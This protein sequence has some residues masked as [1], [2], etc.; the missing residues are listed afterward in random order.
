MAR[1]PSE[2]NLLILK[3]KKVSFGMRYPKGGTNSERLGLSGGRHIPGGHGNLGHIHQNPGHFYQHTGVKSPLHKL[4]HS[5]MWGSWLQTR[6]AQENQQ[7]R[8]VNTGIVMHGKETAGEKG[9]RKVGRRLR[10]ALQIPLLHFI[11]PRHINKM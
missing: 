8:E 1:C 4:Q 5:S 3:A 7:E 9:V 6:L 2:K 11:P 10:S